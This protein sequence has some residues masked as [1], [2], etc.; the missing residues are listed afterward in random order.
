MLDKIVVDCSPLTNII[1]IGRKGTKP[2]ILLEWEDRT[3]EIIGA[4]ADYLLE[5]ALKNENK[6]AGFQWDM[7][8]GGTMT[9]RL[10]VEKGI[11]NGAID[12]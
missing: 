2:N 11:N 4:V 12:R 9:L 6:Q 10:T 7:K 8:D 1:R 5:L 3:D